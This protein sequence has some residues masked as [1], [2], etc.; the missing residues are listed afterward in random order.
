MCRYFLF[1]IILS[2]PCAVCIF[3]LNTYSIIHSSSF[4]LRQYKEILPGVQKVFLICILKYVIYLISKRFKPS[5]RWQTQEWLPSNKFQ[6]QEDPILLSSHHMITEYC[7]QLSPPGHTSVI[8]CLFLILFSISYQVVENSCFDSIVSLMFKTLQLIYLIW[9]TEL[10]HVF[11]K[12]ETFSR[13]TYQ[14]LL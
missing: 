3:K 11:A 10:K 5:Q 8:S 14:C 7:S 4:A 6:V 9:S 1:C 12:I 2:V 13:Y